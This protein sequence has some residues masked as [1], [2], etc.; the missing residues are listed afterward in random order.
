MVTLREN[1][2]MSENFFKKFFIQFLQK[3]VVKNVSILC[4]RFNNL[5]ICQIQ[6]TVHPF[7]NISCM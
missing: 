2:R 5:K 3:N 4:F 7:K 1:A 6:N